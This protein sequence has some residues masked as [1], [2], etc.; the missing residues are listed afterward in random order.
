MPFV[1]EAQRKFMY[2]KHPEIAKRWS[3]EYPDQG[4]LPKKLGAIKRKKD[5]YKRVVDNKMRWQ[6]D[7]DDEKK[8]IRINKEKSKKKSSVIRTIIHEEKHRTSPQMHEKTLT[9]KEAK[10]VKATPEAIK[11]K[12]YSLYRKNPS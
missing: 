5:G 12:L 2:W 6:G 1:S 8:I 7:I 9:K 4:N 11:R 10:M 3:K